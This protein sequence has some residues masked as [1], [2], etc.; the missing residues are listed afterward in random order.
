MG[1]C[2]ISASYKTY[3]GKDKNIYAEFNDV[4]AGNKV[5]MRPDQMDGYVVAFPGE[6]AK[7]KRVDALSNGDMQ[8]VDRSKVDSLCNYM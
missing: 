7:H 2:L 6:M 5:Y 8:E 1:V 3:K 4:R